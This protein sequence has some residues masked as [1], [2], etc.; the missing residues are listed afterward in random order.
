MFAQPSLSG[1]SRLLCA[2]LLVSLALPTLVAPAQAAPPAHTAALKACPNPKPKPAS[3]KVPVYVR[4]SGVSCTYAYALARKVKVKAPK[5]CLV[6]VNKRRIRLSKPC[7][8]SGY[9]C[10]SRSIVDGLALE[11]TCKRGAKMV[12]FQVM[13]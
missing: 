12:R 9:T 2:S 13:Y 8:S 10:T 6:Y 5:G 7:R 1:I 11:A 3:E 4:V